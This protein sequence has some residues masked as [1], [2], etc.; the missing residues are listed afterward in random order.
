MNTKT[1]IML[2]GVAVGAIVIASQR[3]KIMA[4]LMPVSGFADDAAPQPPAVVQAAAVNTAAVAQTINTL[5]TTLAGIA[6]LTLTAMTL[7]EKKRALAKA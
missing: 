3:K 7:A 6:G 1:K 4:L 5:V 2:A